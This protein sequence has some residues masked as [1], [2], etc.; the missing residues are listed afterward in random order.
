MTN[1]CSHTIGSPCDEI[2]SKTFK[3]EREQ[4]Q[5]CDTESLRNKYPP[6]KTEFD[7]LGNKIPMKS[8]K[9]LSI[10]IALAWEFYDE[11]ISIQKMLMNRSAQARAEATVRCAGLQTAYRYLYI[12]GSSDCAVSLSWRRTYSLEKTLVKLREIR[13]MSF[14][15]IAK[16]Q[17]TNKKNKN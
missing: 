15:W 17:K 16:K 11:Q 10:S 3:K 4:A 2:Y 14:W 13:K 7:I 9:E 1:T 12:I 8:F 6:R 5:D